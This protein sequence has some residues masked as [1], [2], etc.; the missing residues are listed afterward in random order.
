MGK[1]QAENERE[2]LLMLQATAQTAQTMLTCLEVAPVRAPEL[3]HLLI[4]NY[5]KATGASQK[6]MARD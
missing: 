2:A 3:C 5:R 6:A 4:R 1:L